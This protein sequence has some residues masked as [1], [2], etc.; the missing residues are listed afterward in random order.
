MNDNDD[1]ITFDAEVK[2]VSA[3]NKGLDKEFAINLLA[4]NPNTLALG[5]LEPMT[6]VR[7]TVVVLE[8]D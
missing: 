5:A 4:I 7:V 3:S 2:K 8:D 1:S 6:R